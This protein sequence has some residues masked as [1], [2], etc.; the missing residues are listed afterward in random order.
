MILNRRSFLKN[1]LAAGSVL[2]GVG[3]LLSA[4]SGITRSDMP[5]VDP[6][7]NS[8]VG[9]DEI[10]T[11]ILYHASL[12]PSGHNSQPWF[13]KVISQNEWIIIVMD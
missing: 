1:F 4:C 2:T 6:V 10:R 8:A 12:A 13:V 11:S 9:L 7:G 3:S 5:Y